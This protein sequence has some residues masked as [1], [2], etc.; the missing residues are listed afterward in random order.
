MNEI[1]EKKYQELLDSACAILAEHFDCVQ[2]MVSSTGGKDIWSAGAGN[3]Y[4]RMGM[5]H[6]IIK[7]DAAIS[8]ASR[9]NAKNNH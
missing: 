2:I 5:I 8:I 1:E 3:Y 9:I 7:D 4:G 6:E